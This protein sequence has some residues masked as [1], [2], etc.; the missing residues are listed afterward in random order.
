VLIPY[1]LSLKDGEHRIETLKP[2]KAKKRKFRFFKLIFCRVMF[3][4]RIFFRQVPNLDFITLARLKVSDFMTGNRIKTLYQINEDLNLGLN[5]VTYMHLGR[6]LKF[7][8][9]KKPE[10]IELKGES[11]E[12]FFLLSLKRVLNQ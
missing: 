8:F 3:S 4:I 11:M 12:N 7:L 9:E 5:L 2:E 1:F 10:L 6:A